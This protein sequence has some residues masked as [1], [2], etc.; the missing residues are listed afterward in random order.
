M[1]VA[2]DEAENLLWI[3]ALT[4]RCSV[5]IGVLVFLRDG[6]Q[7]VVGGW[8][9]PPFQVGICNGEEVSV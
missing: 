9:K 1:Q 5:V 4:L 2:E 8:V 7:C 3:C 6:A